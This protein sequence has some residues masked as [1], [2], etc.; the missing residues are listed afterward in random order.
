MSGKSNKK[1]MP[2]VS[3]LTPSFNHEKYVGF[4][5]E[6]ILAQTNPNWELI[7]VDDCSMDNNV[8]EIKK[9]S[10]SRIKFIQHDY[11]KGINAAINTAFAASSGK[12]ISLIASDDMLYENYVED[13]INTM[14]EKADAGVIYYSLQGID[15]NNNIISNEVLKSV[16]TNRFDALYRCFCK[17]NSFVSPGM[18]IRCE[19]F[20]KLYPLNLALSQYQD[21]KLHIDLCILSE[22]YVSNKKLVKYR[23][24]SEKS[25]ISFA[26][27]RSI[28]QMELEENLLMDSFLKI[29]DIQL[30]RKIFSKDIDK[31]G[32][33]T[34]DII[35]YIL[36]N[37]ALG[38]SNKYKKLWGYNQISKFIS[39]KDNYD[40]INKKYNF[41]YK[42][43][44][45]L[46][47]N[48]IGD[49]PIL[50]IK[51]KYKKYKKLFKLLVFLC[52]LL[53]VFLIY[54]IFVIN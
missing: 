25:G 47:D 12:Y 23:I 45:Q 34:E 13:V 2:I 48:F 35:P 51:K 3:F 21:Y 24:P 9:Y 46:A 36:G 49:D 52:A 7:I 31:Y 5:I 43:F 17:G 22:V 27:D 8:S 32:E 39:I 28:M 42:N 6:S 54:Y 40:K 50:L 20:Q 33:I 53:T 19:I 41:C 30:L 16:V 37:L 26:S 4:F 1:N 10:D 44:L 29:K 18:C 15:N 14:S 38:S 11:N